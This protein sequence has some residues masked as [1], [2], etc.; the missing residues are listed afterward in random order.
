MA[1]DITT[2]RRNTIA[3]GVLR[4]GYEDDCGHLSQGDKGQMMGDNYTAEVVES[5]AAMVEKMQ[6]NFSPSRTV[7]I[8]HSGGAALTALLASR[9][10]ELLDQAIL[11]ACP[12]NLK[13]WRKSMTALTENSQWKEPME[14]LS[15]LAEVSQL[16]SECKNPSFRRR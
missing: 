8:G 16:K 15:P 9:R 11:V 1:K 2:A 12:C 5:L 6:R 7:M 10:P 14:G 13:D 4:P 3:V